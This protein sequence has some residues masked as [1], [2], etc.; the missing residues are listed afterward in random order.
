MTTNTDTQFTSRFPGITADTFNG[1]T[2]TLADW[3]P[4]EN[5]INTGMLSDIARAYIYAPDTQQNFYAR[6]LQSA[7]SRGDSIMSARVSEI[8]SKAYDPNAADSAL[9]DGTRP[10]MISNVA[11]KNL[12]RQIRLLSSASTGP[13]S[14][15][16]FLRCTAISWRQCPP[17]ST[18]VISTTCGPLRRSTFPAPPVELRQLR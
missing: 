3:Q 6:F 7:L 15:R 12:S 13:S 5:T 2:S 18:R 1:N 11:K 14:S 4:T 17:L 8:A 16:R 9:F 10:T